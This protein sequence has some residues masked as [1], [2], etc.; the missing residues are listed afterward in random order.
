MICQ[1]CGKILTNEQD[2]YGHDCEVFGKME[3]MK[4]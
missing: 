1:E 4:L 3:V 2:A